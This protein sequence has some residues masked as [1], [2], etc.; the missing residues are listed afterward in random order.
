MEAYNLPLLEL[1]SRLREAGLPLG[2]DEY[3]LVLYSL[4]SGFGINDKAA[5]KRL[6]QTLWIK[7]AEERRLFDYHFEYLIG[8]EVSLTDSHENKIASK[9]NLSTDNQPEKSENTTTSFNQ[10]SPTSKEPSKKH[11]T[12]QVFSYAIIT[13]LEVGILLAVGSTS[14]QSNQPTTVTQPIT[15]LQPTATPQPTT[16]SQPTATPQ[17]TTTSQPTATPQPTNNNLYWVVGITLSVIVLS[18]SYAIFRLGVKRIPKQQL[19]E[20]EPNASPSIP[21]LAQT[22]DDEVQ[23]A[24]AVLQTS[25]GH[26]GISI[27]H[28]M[29]TSNYLPVTERQLKQIWRHLR[30]IVRE[31]VTTE[32]D[33]EATVNQIGRQ[34]LLL[35]PILVPRRV[36]VA[37][38]LLLI[39]QDGSM[40]PFHSLSQRLAETAL[41]G[42][43]LGKAG[44]YYFHNCPTDYLYHDPHHQE[45][46]LVDDIVATICFERTSILIFSDA[47]AARASLSE[48]RY[49]ATKEFLNKLKQQVRYIA[50]L[51]PMPKKRWFGTT[52]GEIA[53]LVPMF[54]VSREGVLD[55]V[56]VLRGR[57]Q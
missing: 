44:I 41:R 30:R 17:P 55:A 39:D 18:A 8:S 2:I 54:E 32:L 33:L 45:A 23:V 20:L 7:T 43:R 25:K 15:T 22:I 38:M 5:L 56:G 27:N 9:Q 53:N 24:K 42:G 1:F 28:F 47:G 4:Q 49:D 37:Q 48:E 19:K 36:N 57:I 3:Q 21:E 35:Q 14:K 13:L 29:L 11:K 12:Y 50:W 40:V 34:G 51:N 6:C 52:A 31:G 26:E 10:Q 16:T 46:A